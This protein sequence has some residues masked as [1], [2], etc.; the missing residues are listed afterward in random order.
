MWFF[1][2]RMVWQLISYTNPTVLYSLSTQLSLTYSLWFSYIP[3]MIQQHTIHDS[4]TFH[5]WF[6]YIPSMTLHAMYIPSMTVLHSIHDCATFHPWLCYIPSMTLLHPNHDSA[7]S[8]SILC[9]IMSMLYSRHDSATPYW[10]RYTFLNQL[11]STLD[12]HLIPNSNTQSLNHLNLI[13]TQ[14]TCLTFSTSH[15]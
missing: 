14:S 10:L 5:P 15:P 1:K 4:A 12:V 9:Y 2:Q 6:S 11:L 7:T 8:P 3:S 13:T